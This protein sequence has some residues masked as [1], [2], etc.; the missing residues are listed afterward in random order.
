M[1]NGYAGKLLFVNLSTG[2]IR[3][4]V[5]D[6]GLYRDF[7]GGYGLGAR[8]LYTHMRPGVDP[9]GPENMLGLV[10]GVLT[11]TP[12]T[13]GVRFQAVGKSPLTGG[14]GDASAGGHF[15]PHLK[16]AGYDAVFFSGAA[17]RPVYLFIDS[18]K[19]ELRDA[20]D[21]W[22]ADIYETEATLKSRHGANTRIACIGPAGEKQTLIACIVN[23]KGASA[24]RSGLGAVMGSKRLKAVAVRG[25][26]EFPIADRDRALK[27]RQ[28]HIAQLQQATME[29]ESLWENMHKYGTSS[30]TAKIALNGDTPIKNFGGIG[31]VDYPD[32]GTV[33]G[34][35]AI[36]NQVRDETCWQCP[37]LCEGIL[38]PGTGKY[39]YEAGSRR[40]EYETQASFGGFLLN[41]DGE[42][43]AKV[44]DICNR[45]GLDTISAGTTVAFAIECF[46]N[47]ILNLEDTDGIELRWGS[48]PAIV[49]L[50]EKIAR[51]EGLGDVLA[52][53][54]KRAAERIGRGAEKFAVHIGGQELGMHDPK[55]QPE[56]EQ[57]AGARYLVDATPGRHTQGFGRRGLKGHIVNSSGL[58]FFGYFAGEPEKTIAGF[59]SAVTGWERSWDEL[60]VCAERIMAIRQAFNSREGINQRRDWPVHPR[61]VGIPPQAE[62]PLK[63]VTIDM[64]AQV[65]HHMKDLGW[66]PET[67]KPTKEKLLELGLDDLAR[68]LWP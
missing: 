66:D 53:G 41:N 1:P 27:L 58:C 62:G 5:P 2:E 56:L 42:V 30:G 20:S 3:A 15:G 21:L 29:G 22:G 60:C 44:N 6:E 63:G 39:K 31:I 8:I 32:P 45:A 40:P 24:G 35:G 19:A 28:E 47:G 65:E 23:E 49:A 7:I 26:L 54:V 36:A 67:C 14:W 46:E 57:A 33:S 38:G 25:N 4:E 59:I 51:R 68:D 17:E 37:L 11:G 9:L 13:M 18:G 64:D 61:I 48:G 52:D 12:A 50:T 10:T 16:F 55:F 34:D 43:V